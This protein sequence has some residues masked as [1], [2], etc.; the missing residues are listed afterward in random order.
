MTQSWHHSPVHRFVP[1][2]VYI[3]TGGTLY[4]EHFFQ[5]AERLEFFQNKLLEVLEEHEWLIQAWAVFV[6]HYHLIAEAPKTG[7]C[8]SALINEL[9]SV[10]AAEVN[11]LDAMIGR[12]VWYQYWDTCLT[13]EKSWLARLNY[14]HNNAVHHGLVK[15]AENYPYCSASWFRQKA[16]PAFVRKVNSFR[17][18]RL[19]IVDDF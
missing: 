11:R 16:N 13:Y 17:T 10:T 6:N 18:D 19:K 8:L 2:G 12:Q 7:K 3:V 15:L 5:G 14:V 1:E 9:H 4:K